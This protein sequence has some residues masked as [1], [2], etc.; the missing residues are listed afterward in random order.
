MRDPVVT[1][2]RFSSVVDRCESHFYVS[3]ISFVAVV[4]HLKQTI[5]TL[6]NFYKTQ[7]TFTQYCQM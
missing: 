6:K 2:T 5:L 7:H 3:L 4:P 1:E